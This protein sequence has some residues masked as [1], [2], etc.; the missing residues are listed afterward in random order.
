M[1]R[2][3]ATVQLKLLSEAAKVPL[4]SLKLPPEAAKVPLFS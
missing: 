4:F 1:R 2:R 3:G